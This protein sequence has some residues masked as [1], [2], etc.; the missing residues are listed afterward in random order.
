MLAHCK[1]NQRQSDL[2]LARVI[3][4]KYRHGQ[5]SKLTFPMP[6]HALIYSEDIKSPYFQFKRLRCLECEGGL[7]FKWSKELQ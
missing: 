5:N 3:N 2:S 1:Y 6:C 4:H 7:V